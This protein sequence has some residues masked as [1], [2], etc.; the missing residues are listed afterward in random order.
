MAGGS[1][2]KTRLVAEIAMWQKS[3][4]TQEK[5]ESKGLKSNRS[6]DIC[7]IVNVF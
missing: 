4:I 2:L 3:V 7:L 5:N 6:F 1:H